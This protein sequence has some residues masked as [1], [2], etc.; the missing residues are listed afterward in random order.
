[1]LQLQGDRLPETQPIALRFRPS[2]A[3]GERR[4][5]ILLIEDDPHQRTGMLRPLDACG[6]AAH[7]VDSAEAGL[8]AI[9]AQDAYD[10]VICDVG[11]PRLSGA[12]LAR[13][14][15][16]PLLIAY[17]G[18]DEVPP[19]FDVGRTKPAVDALVRLVQAPRLTLVITQ[20]GDDAFCG[21]CLGT[22]IERQ[23]RSATAAHRALTDALADEP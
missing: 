10:A 22:G 3:R 13:R 8:L 2:V 11:L 23:G 12:E 6:V 5:R 16:Q 1:M 4:P 19:W 9:A 7:H 21:R 15:R 20:T 17:S 18:R 14:L